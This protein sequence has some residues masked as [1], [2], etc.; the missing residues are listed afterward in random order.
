M[1][2][3]I[4][5]RGV[6]L[7]E[8]EVGDGNKILT[9]F[10]KDYGKVTV[11]ANGAK[12]AT[13][14][15]LAGTQQFTY[16]DYVVTK[17]N[18]FYFLNSAEIIRSFYTITEDYDALCCAL[19]C[20]EIINKNVVEHY[21]ANDELLLLIYAL[22][23]LSKKANPRLVLAMFVMK[24]MQIIGLEPY[25]DTCSIC[26]ID[27]FESY[28]FGFEGLICE[29]CREGEE[30]IKISKA[31]VDLMIAVFEADPNTMYKDLSFIKTQNELEALLRTSVWY[32]RQH[33]EI[34]Y[35]TLSSIIQN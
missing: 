20:I 24:F 31:I 27:E 19:V 10:A 34:N 29:E 12:K 4:L 11:K 33:T 18:N 22:N 30:V 5:L 17:Q 2:E 15:F 21:E 7:Q 28:Y 8:T 26:Q 6:I 32:L 1:S 14:K 3:Q 23:T 13:S 25:L 35:N 16:C 9:I